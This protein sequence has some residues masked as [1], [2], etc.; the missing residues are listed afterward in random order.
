MYLKDSYRL[1]NSK[2]F[3]KKKV[4]KNKNY[5]GRKYNK[6]IEIIELTFDTRN[7]FN[8][9]FINDK[10]KKFY[11]LFDWRNWLY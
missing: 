2:R 4:N 8:A 3:Y 6:N 10:L 1:I 5:N 7:S 9:T 11:P